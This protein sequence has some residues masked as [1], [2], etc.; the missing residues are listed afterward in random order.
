MTVNV[1][2]T[3]N[4]MTDVQKVQFI[5]RVVNLHGDEIKVA[6]EDAIPEYLHPSIEKVDLMNMGSTLVG[7]CYLKSETRTTV[8][9]VAVIPIKILGLTFRE[10]L[11][12][13]VGGEDSE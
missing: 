8:M 1:F 11:E 3:I 7:R 4:S 12:E 2:D 5:D 10:L 13:K 6:C 9:T